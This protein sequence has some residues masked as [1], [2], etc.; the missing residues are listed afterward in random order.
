MLLTEMMANPTGGSPTRISSN[1]TTND[2]LS[3]SP[4][5]TQADEQS[6]F[7]FVADNFALCWV[8]VVVSLLVITVILLWIR[9]CCYTRFGWNCCRGSAPPSESRRPDQILAAQLRMEL[10][11][12]ARDETADKQKECSR[13][14]LYQQFLNSYTR[15]LRLQDFVLDPSSPTKRA[16]TVVDGD[17]DDDD[18]TVSSEL[19]RESHHHSSSRPK[20]RPGENKMRDCECSESTASDADDDD[21]DLMIQFTTDEEATDGA[22]LCASATCSICLHHYRPGDSI[23][24]SAVPGCR[25]VYHVDCMLLWAATG[26]KRCPVCRKYFLPSKRRVA[27]AVAVQAAAAAASHSSSSMIRDA[28]TSSSGSS[29][30]ISV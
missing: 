1:T 17:E 20:R 11:Q 2:E 24:W 29:L 27:A 10:A 18:N 25:H 14:E 9:D 6:L 13:L 23:V 28:S 3:S 12:Q 15:I 5:T 4:T 16:T 21:E 30:C 8:I 22:Q 7:G 19:A 26:K